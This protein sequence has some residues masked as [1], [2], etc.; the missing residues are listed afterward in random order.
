LSAEREH[1]S[2]SSNPAASQPSGPLARLLAWAPIHL[3]T[4]RTGRH[5]GMVV[6]G[7][8]VNRILTF[9]VHS[10]L[11]RALEKPVFAMF[12]VTA[13]ALEVVTELADL[14][15]NVNL[16]RNYSRHAERNR[17]AAL[18]VIQLVLRI[19]V[20]WVLFLTVV[21]YAF[22]PRFALLLR[23]PELTGPFRF[24]VLGLAAPVMVYFA[25]AHLQAVRWFGR[26]VLVNIVERIG[27][28]ALVSILAVT[29]YI[30]L[31]PA[32]TI[33]ILSPFLAAV[34][35]LA[36][37]P[38]DYFRVR[39]IEP[40]VAREV[41]HFGK[42]AL[43]SSLL[44]LALWRLDVFMLTALST[45]EKL[46]DYLFAVRLIALLQV[47][48]QGFNT[49]LLPRVGRFESVAECHTY[50]RMIG[51]LAPVVM[52]GAV[53]LCLIAQ[54]LLLIPFGR[55]AIEAVP[56]FRLLVVGEALMILAVPIS[57]LFYRLN[58]VD[59][60]CVTNILLLVVCA[61]SNGVLIPRFAGMGAAMAYLLVRL[62]A[63]L[64]TLILLSYALGK[65]THLGKLD[66]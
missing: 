41:F 8:A 60:I 38:H 52:L 16:V 5:A 57:L 11:A 13:M 17:P 42:W 4:S 25:L 15:L 47:V 20:V 63:V 36:L 18:S 54:P 51:K 26:Y 50:L 28:L 35:G 14:G 43:V 64:S 34:L 6:G 12:N 66:D 59:L 3:A 21:L 40:G 1:V 22:A 62:T 53:L 45:E 9:L 58:R 44:T 37:A 55:K 33:W 24:A 46:A 61:A 29:G 32:L 56:I 27:L 2:D 23:K 49:A 65:V 48:T 39:R 30:G 31:Y 7:N 19:K 10:V